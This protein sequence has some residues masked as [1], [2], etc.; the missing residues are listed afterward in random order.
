[1]WRCWKASSMR[2]A[3]AARRLREMAANSLYFF[4]DFGDYEAKAAAKFLNAE[5]A[6]ILQQLHD[7]F[8]GA[9]GLE[10]ARRSTRSIA[11]VAERAGA[12]LGKVAQP[13]RVAMTGGTVSPPIDLTVAAAR[14]RAHAGPPARALSR[15]AARPSL[16]ARKWRFATPPNG[17]KFSTKPLFCLTVSG[18]LRKFA[19]LSWGHSS[20]GRALAWH[21]RGRRFDPAWLHHFR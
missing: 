9:G 5:T 6:P 8:A 12:G 11:A 2:S 15:Y 13:L 21:A 18:G 17:P 14:A 16:T 19:T 7:G 10:C 1:M 3:S 4:Q 20:A